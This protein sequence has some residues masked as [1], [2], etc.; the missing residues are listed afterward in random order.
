MRGRSCELIQ[1]EAFAQ[2][3][4]RYGRPKTGCERSLE[5]DDR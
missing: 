4:E 2:S 1:T 5:A 3:F